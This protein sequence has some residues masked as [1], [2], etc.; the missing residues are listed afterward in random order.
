LN[1]IHWDERDAKLVGLDTA[2]AHGMLMDMGIGGGYVKSG[3]A[4]R[5]R[6]KSTTSVYRGGAGPNDGKAP[7]LCQRKGQVG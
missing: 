2:I 5:V 7:S 4:I 1:T 6:S 3:T